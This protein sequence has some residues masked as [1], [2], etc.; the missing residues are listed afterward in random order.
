M[1]MEYCPLGNLEDLQSVRPKQYISAFR[2]ILDGL[3]YI[4]SNHVA[5]RDLKPANLLV[6]DR[7]PLHIKISDFGLSKA[8]GVLRTACG[9]KL[10]AAPEV[11]S[12]DSA[13]YW[14]SVD[15]W[16]T[17][18]I[19]MQFL[20]GLPEW[21]NIIYLPSDKRWLEEWST[22]LVKQIDD[23]DKRKDLIDLLKHIVRRNPKDRFSAD[24]CLEM[25]GDNGLFKRLND[26]RIVDADPP[27]DDK[28][29]DVD[30]ETKTE[31]AT[32]YD[33][34]TAPSDCSPGPPRP[35]KAMTG[36]IGWNFSSR[37]SPTWVT[38]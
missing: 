28:G 27:S 4:H 31:V 30:T 29:R 22:R 6:V 8:D 14:P 3:R 12:N 9:T 33:T 26:G 11:Y 17:G 32:P 36:P 19:A 38:I 34:N 35:T 10:Y 15:M 20:I 23:C 2:Q 13:G 5:H 37:R 7:H 1:V 16:S 24:Q 25:G 21:I 18:V